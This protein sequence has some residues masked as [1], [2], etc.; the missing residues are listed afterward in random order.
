MDKQIVE[1]VEKIA[2]RRGYRFEQRGNKLLLRHETAPFYVEVSE[3]SR[4]LRVRIGYESLK[5]YIREV[6]DSEA[7]PQDYIEDI[8][9]SMSALAHE[10]FEELKRRG[11]NVFLEAREAVMDVLEELEEAL[12]E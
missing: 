6:V 8:L 2:R 5:D 7:D 12:E 1:A 4:G 3:T 10:V 11:Y 9:D